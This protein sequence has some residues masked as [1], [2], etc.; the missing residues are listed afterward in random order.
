MSGGCDLTRTPVRVLHAVNKMDRGGIETFLMRL[1]REIDRSRVQFDF[2]VHKPGQGAYDDEIRALGGRIYSIKFKY[3]P[4]YMQKYIQE[5]KRFFDSHPE[6]IIVHAHL[7]AF[8]GILLSLAARSGIKERIAHIHAQSSG[9]R[10]REPVWNIV[11]RI[12]RSSFT[13][14]YSCSDLAGKWAY[15]GHAKF[16]I[17]KNAF[18]VKQF[19]FDE[20][21]RTKLRTEYGLE[22][23]TV[24]GHV[25][26][27]RP[28]KNQIFLPDVLA[29]V[30][31]HNKDAYLLLVGV[32]SEQLAVKARIEEL[33]LSNYVIFAGEASVPENFYSAMDIFVLP[34]I[35]EG[36]G[37]VAIEAQAS[38]LPTIL[39]AGVPKEAM[40]TK[41]A[42]RIPLNGN[43]NAKEW[44]SAIL[45]KLT[46]LPSRLVD[47]AE[48]SG[49]D[50]VKT[51]DSLE[52]I[53]LNSFN[54]V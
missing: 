51:A 11:K 35:N 1:Y 45:Q 50:I 10:F 32:G 30:R 36:L 29:K 5:L 48:L 17:I 2:L 37:I 13:Q 38:G 9:S 41:L 34:S 12:G 23:C 14:R 4:F 44:A 39:S 7:N 26:A 24:I 40:A 25:G 31:E 8:N 18:P 47:Q 27:F 19:S 16:S 15:G 28:S 21:A 49:F 33:E 3:N 6:Y 22:G 42:S 43:S 52:Q 54:K 53:Y 20:E 46:E